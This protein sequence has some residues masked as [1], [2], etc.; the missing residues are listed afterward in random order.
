MWCSTCRARTSWQFTSSCHR[1]LF[2]LPNTRVG[3]C[4]VPPQRLDVNV[5]LDRPVA[6]FANFLF[7]F[8]GLTMRFAEA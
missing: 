8:R 7:Q 3:R 4:D 2:H 1:K 6:Q 5:H